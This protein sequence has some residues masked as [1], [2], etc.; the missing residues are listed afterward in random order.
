MND[1]TADH[2]QADEEMPTDTLSDEALESAGT[3]SAP[4]ITNSFIQWSDPCCRHR[5][6]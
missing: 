4:Q 5:Q 6:G 1:Q 3:D 2:T